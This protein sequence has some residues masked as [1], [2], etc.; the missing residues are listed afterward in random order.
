V[1][2]EL[3]HLRAAVNLQAPPR[4]LADG[5]DLPEAAATGPEP[6]TQTARPVP[7]GPP[8]PPREA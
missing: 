5:S 1:E 3:M 8:H 2:H 7:P 4:H 6:R